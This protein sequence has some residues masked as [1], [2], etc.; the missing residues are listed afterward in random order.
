M[1]GFADFHFQISVNVFK[2]FESVVFQAHSIPPPPLVK[3]VACTVVFLSSDVCR[4]V[5]D[6]A[7]VQL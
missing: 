3:V 7:Y 6:G 1:F 5:H 4:P 2:E